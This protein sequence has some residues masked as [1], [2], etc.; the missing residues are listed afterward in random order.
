LPEKVVKGSLSFGKTGG[1]SA[2]GKGF[3]VT[4][5]EF[6]GPIFP[7]WKIMGVFTQDFLF[8][9]RKG[10]FLLWEKPRCGSY[11]RGRK[12]LGFLHIILPLFSPVVE[13]KNPPL[14]S[15][16]SREHLQ[17]DGGMFFSG[18]QQYGGRQNEH[19]F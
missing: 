7:L 14:F 12:P 2:Q 9:P 3:S 13:K 5:R 6:L 18:G 1:G 11:P 16:A 17:K 8:F 10:E 4:S 15:E 19:N